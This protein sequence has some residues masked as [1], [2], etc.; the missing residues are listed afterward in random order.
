MNRKTTRYVSLML[1]I[2]IVCMIMLLYPFMPGSY[3]PLAVPL[4]TFIQLYSGL[5][6]LTCIPS[7]LWF[8]KVIRLK[9]IDTVADR[10]YASWRFAKGFVWSN[11]IIIAL[12]VS[13]VMLSTSVLAGVLLMLISIHYSRLLL[14]KIARANEVTNAVIPLLLLLLPITLFGCHLFVM[15]PLTTWSRNKAIQNCS[16]LIQQIEAHKKQTGSYPLTISGL[17]SDYKTGITGI[18]VYHYAAD[19]TT[20]NLYFEQPRFLFDQLGTRELV[21]YNPTDNHVILS[22]AVWHLQMTPNARRNNQGWYSAHNTDT[23]HWKY[24]WFD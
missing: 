14:R 16:E 10:P 11:L 22:H 21:V 15:K 4:A 3:D 2:Y 23:P 5:G 6:L 1:V 13:L 12:C 17:H 19:K 7:A 18:D 9:K 24:F 8:Y 20:F